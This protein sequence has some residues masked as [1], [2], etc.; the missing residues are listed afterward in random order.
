MET[1][2]KQRLVGALVLVALAVIFLPM[3]VKGPAPASGVDDVSLEAP[4]VP[5]DGFETRVLPLDAPVADGRAALP[6]A[7]TLA[8]APAA[9]PAPA[10]ASGAMMPAATA[11]GEYAVTFGSYATQPDAARVV[12]A[13]QASQ[14]PGY[15]EPYTNAAGRTLHR[16]RVGPFVTQAEAEAAR[17]RAASV[18]DDVGSKVIAL[19]AGATAT[20]AATASKAPASTTAP[21]ASAPVSTPTPLPASPTPKT[22]P[23]A[24]T[25]A[26]K[27]PPLSDAQVKAK[28]AAAEPKPAP[29]VGQAAE[30]KP[31]NSPSGASGVGFAVQLGAF[32]NAEEA[33][34]LRDRARAAG[35]SA[36]VE[37]V[38]TDKG[39]LNRVR[40][41]PVADRGDADRM[42][43]QAASQLGVSGLVRPHP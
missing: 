2:L 18:R 10:P 22:E 16:V 27:A 19:D 6:E 40:I 3:L 30:P 13:L 15:Q 42:R 8:T 20:S 32:G 39:T 4:D 35:F 33:A 41:G 14:L 25:D 24:S 12:A 17:L 11:G 29:P 36:F 38:R 26:R 43:A 1:A 9:T 21:L 28:T 23:L 5:E 7:A 37:Q 34:R 31:D